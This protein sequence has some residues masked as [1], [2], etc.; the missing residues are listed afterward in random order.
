MEW[1][2]LLDNDMYTM[3]RPGWTEGWVICALRCVSLGGTYLTYNTTKK[4]TR[5]L[6]FIDS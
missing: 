4:H 3:S 1:L 6:V 5:G 2:G